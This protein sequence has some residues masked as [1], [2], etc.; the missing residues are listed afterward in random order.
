MSTEQPATMD[1]QC[2][3]CAAHLTVKVLLAG[4]KINCPKCHKKILIPLE[5]GGIAQ[6][7]DQASASTPPSP[8][9]APFAPVAPPP[10][11]PPVA[12]PAIAPP[13]AAP[14]DREAERRVASLAAELQQKADLVAER[15]RE[16]QRLREELSAQ[17]RQE[18]E[19][20]AEIERLRNEC[21]TAREKAESG[22][23]VQ[24]ERIRI[25]TSRADGDLERAAQRI[26]E[27]E[28][29]V[30]KARE[31]AQS[32]R[33]SAVTAGGVDT[34]VD[35]GPNPDRLIADLQG[36]TLRRGLRISIVAHAVFLLLTS[37]GFIYWSL[38]GGRPQVQRAVP[39]EASDDSLATPVTPP[40]AADA[41][42]AASPA[43]NAPSA[44]PIAPRPR[45]AIEE[46][47]ES[48]PEPGEVPQASDISLDIE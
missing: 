27:L 21:R 35:D 29:Q 2:G 41:A 23:A 24:G 30:A 15:E 39:I 32:A 34:D 28:K 25:A 37:I 13:P 38:R 18:T 6:S 26:A 19:R 33:A 42:L 43:T 12:A 31:E 17:Q 45:S 9:P 36:S 46:I 14:P 48:L 11:Q 22:E 47:I 1:F 4:K 8:P 7:P 3:R 10:P 44:T 20:V 16:M 40:T 5:S